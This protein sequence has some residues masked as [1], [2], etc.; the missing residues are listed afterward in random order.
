VNGPSPDYLAQLRTTLG[1]APGAPAPAAPPPPVD[2]AS[3]AG[4]ALGVRPDGPVID[5]GAI[6]KGGF[7][8]APPPAPAAPHGPPPPPPPAELIGPPADPAPVTAPEPRPQPFLHQVSGGGIVHQAAHETELR[9]PQL[10]VAQQHRNEIVQGAIGEVKDR[11]AEQVAGDFRIA[12]QQEDEARARQQASE[13]AA[14]QQAQEMQKRQADFDQSVKALSQMSVEPG[15]FWSNAN[16]GQKLAAVIS[17][18][19]GGFVAARNGGRNPGQEQINSLIDNDIKAQEFAYH[20][21]H[22][23]ANA[24]QTAFSMAMDKYKNADQARAAAR[25]ASLDAAQA[26]MAQ[27]AALWKGTDAANRATM[28]TAGLEDDKTEQIRQG[29]A[30]TSPR[31]VGVA[32]QWADAD[33]IHYSEQ[34]VRDLKK[35]ERGQEHDIRKIGAETAGA[36]I[37]EGAKE[38]KTTAKDERALSVKLPNG[39]VVKGRDAVQ[40]RELSEAA[41]ASHEIARLTAQAKEIRSGESFRI[42]GHPQRARLEQIQKNL[43]TNYAVMHKLGAISGPDMDLATGGTAKLFDVGPGPEAALDSLNDTAQANIRNIVKT[44]PDAPGTAKGEMPKS[45]TSHGGK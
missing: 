11:I 17:L 41:Q 20:A 38:D 22:D 5:N 16:V 3:Q 6:A 9:G 25:A 34:Q 24:K 32:P 19:L 14:V 8:V 39:D 21:A 30:F 36:L 33:G 37:K 42:P 18:S 43:I 7:T 29:V 13:N 4:N 23:T 40:T 2:F 1:P 26:Q 45:F 28:A 31:D 10:K 12:N 27:Q 35:E 44:I 15:R